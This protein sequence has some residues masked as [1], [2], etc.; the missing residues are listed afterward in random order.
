[1]DTQKVKLFEETP[2][3]GAVMSLSVP[4]ILSSLVMVIYN[5]ADTYFGNGCHCCISTI[6]SG[7]E[8]F[9]QGRG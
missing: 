1:M 7:T 9:W 6:V 3:P 5:M 8:S 4:A 2:I